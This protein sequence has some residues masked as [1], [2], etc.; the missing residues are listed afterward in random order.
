MTVTFDGLEDNAT[1]FGSNSVEELH[2]QSLQ[3]EQELDSARDRLAAVTAE[4][5]SLAGD[6]TSAEL[7]FEAQCLD[8]QLQRSLRSWAAQQFAGEAIEAQAAEFE[9]NHQPETLSAASSILS[10]LTCGRHRR[11][12]TPLTARRLMIEDDTGV[13]RP[14]ED[15]S[16]GTR[17]QLFLAV[18]LA[19]V[20]RLAQQGLVLPVLL[21]DVI[22]NFDQS[23]SEAAVDELMAFASRGHQ[24]L[25]LTCHLHLA[26]MF[27]SRGVE[28]RWLSSPHESERIAG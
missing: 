7:R 5:D 26:H 23:R 21:D 15:L 13:S 2:Q 18:R 22:V 11:I 12:W 24:L 10:R 20:E 3:F 4:L 28:P 25:F 9:R 6:S 19:V 27:K 14:C 16:R 1:D 8:Q 17:E